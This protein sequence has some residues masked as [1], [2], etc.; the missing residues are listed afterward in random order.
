MK[1]V[2][3]VGKEK[4]AKKNCWAVYSFHAPRIN[5]VIQSGVFV[6]LKNTVNKKTKKNE[7]YVSNQNG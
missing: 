7:M 3:G 4:V 1:L 2:V 5:F 6:P